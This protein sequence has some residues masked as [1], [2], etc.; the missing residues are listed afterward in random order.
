MANGNDGNSPVCNQQYEKS[1]S[2]LPRNEN[3]CWLKDIIANNQTKDEINLEF[4]VTEGYSLWQLVSDGINKFYGF[5]SFEGLQENCMP[6][7]DKG[8]FVR[9]K[10]KPEVLNDVE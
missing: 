4:G 8:V 2:F 6:E 5:D 7:F 9:K 10:V 3:R 1:K